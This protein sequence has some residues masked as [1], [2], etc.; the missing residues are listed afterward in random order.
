[1]GVDAEQRLVEAQDAHGSDLAQEPSS[2]GSRARRR[3][4]AP[5]RSC[6]RGDPLVG[7]VAVEVDAVGV[8]AGVPRRARRGCRRDAPTGSMPSNLGAVAQSLRIAAGRG[9]L[10]CMARSARTSAARLAEVPG[11]DRPAAAR[12]G[13]SPVVSITAGRP[14]PRQRAGT[15]S[16]VGRAQAARRARAAASVRASERRTAQHGRGQVDPGEHQ[17]R[18]PACPH[19]RAPTTPDPRDQVSSMAPEA[20][21]PRWAPADQD[22]QAA[23]R[24]H[25]PEPQRDDADQ[26]TTSDGVLRCD[27]EHHPGAEGEHPARPCAR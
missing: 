5:I 10:P 23:D 1:M 16:S 8:L 9:S 14:R 15:Q 19:G 24:H 26:T 12:S 6:R 4:R 20:C 18:R 11:H 7:V 2:R 17:R 22:Q 27:Q 21:L 3:A 25:P 13:R